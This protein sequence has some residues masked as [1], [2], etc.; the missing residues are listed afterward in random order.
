MGAALCECAAIGSIGSA[1]VV[2]SEVEESLS[3]RGKRVDEILM[4]TD[5][6][7]SWTF[8]YQKDHEGSATHLTNGSGGADEKDYLRFVAILRELVCRRIR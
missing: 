6:A 8:Y 5:V 1:F 3:L 7:Q 2:P 4:R